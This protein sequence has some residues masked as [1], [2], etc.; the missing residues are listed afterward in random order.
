MLCQLG[1]ANDEFQ[2]VAPPAD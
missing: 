1:V 2:H